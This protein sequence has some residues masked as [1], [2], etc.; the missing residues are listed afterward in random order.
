MA[1]AW[2]WCRALTPPG[3]K[4]V[5]HLCIRNTKNQKL[6]AFISAIPA[7]IRLKS[8]Y[9]EHTNGLLGC[10]MGDR[11]AR[12]RLGAVPAAIS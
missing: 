6:L 10:G 2:V 12:R 1:H 3:W 8:Q 5:W 11:G 9:V 7:E 4:P